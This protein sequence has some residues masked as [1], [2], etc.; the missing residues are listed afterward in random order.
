MAKEIPTQHNSFRSFFKSK[1]VLLQIKQLNVIKFCGHDDISP[2]VVKAISSYI[3]KPLTHIFNL[4]FNFLLAKFQMHL[5]L[6]L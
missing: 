5:K 4:S 2:K 6:P 3:V 1:D